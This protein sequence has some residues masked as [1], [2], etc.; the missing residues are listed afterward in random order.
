MVESKVFIRFLDV[1]LCCIVVSN[2][3]LLMGLRSKVN[4]EL[5]YRDVD[6]TSFLSSL[7]LLVKKDASYALLDRTLKL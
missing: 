6:S 4:I 1:C 2:M 5:V 7:G 3:Y